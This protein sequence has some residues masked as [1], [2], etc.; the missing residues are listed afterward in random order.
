MA[1]VKLTHYLLSVRNNRKIR[2]KE[3]KCTLYKVL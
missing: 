3:I 2:E 1:E